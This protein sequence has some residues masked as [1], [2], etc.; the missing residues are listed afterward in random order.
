M[1]AFII[2]ERKR[3]TLVSRGDLQ[4]VGVTD[5][6]GGEGEEEHLLVIF[7]G[8]QFH[9]QLRIIAGGE[10]EKRERVKDE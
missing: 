7:G 8:F 2:S 5:T 1:S 6:E 10:R 3:K 9:M 4:F